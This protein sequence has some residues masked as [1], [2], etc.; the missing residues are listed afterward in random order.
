MCVFFGF[1]NS[2]LGEAVFRHHF[3]EDVH[4]RFRREHRLHETVVVDR[5]FGHADRHR[6]LNRLFP[7]KTGK[8]P[9]GQRIQDFAGAVGAEVG[10]QHRVAVFKSLIVADYGRNHEFVADFFGIRSFDRLDRVGKTFAVGHNHVVVGFFHPVPALVAVHGVETSGH[11]GDFDVF[12]GGGI[13]FKFGDEA[14]GRFRRRVAAV[15]K[16]V[17]VGF[18]AV[19]VQNAG[20]RDDVMLGRVNAA[21][22]HQA[23]QVAGF[24][25]FFQFFDQF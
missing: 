20:Q 3:A 25:V 15:Q 21:R 7:F 24:A 14:G 23:H 10:H 13:F 12:H 5:I 17:D 9:V 6:Q 2:Q 8:F 4:Q 19:F 22:R 11:G 16:G 18:D 1:G